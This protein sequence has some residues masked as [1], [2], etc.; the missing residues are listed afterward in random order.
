VS[1]STNSGLRWAAALALLGLACQQSV[2]PS[3]PV[4]RPDDTEDGGAPPPLG[5]RDGGADVP[6]AGPAPCVGTVFGEP[7]TKI[8]I[9][10]DEQSEQSLVVLAAD[11]DGDGKADFVTTGERNDTT[12]HLNDGQGGFQPRPLG[13]GHV[14]VGQARD[15]D[16]NGALDLVMSTSSEFTDTETIDLWLNDGRGTFTRQMLTD[17]FE[18]LTGAAIITDFDGDGALDVVVTGRIG[19]RGEAQSV[20]AFLNRGATFEELPIDAGEDGDPGLA[21]GDLDGDGRMDI[22]FRNQPAQYRYETNIIWNQPRA[23]G[24]VPDLG[25]FPVVADVDGDGRLDLVGG[26]LLMHNEGGRRFAPVKLGSRPMNGDS[27]VLAVDL[28]GDGDLDLLQRD[29]SDLVIFRQDAPMRFS[30]ARS[31]IPGKPWIIFRNEQFLRLSAADLTGDGRPDAVLSDHGGR[32]HLVSNEILLGAFSRR[33]NVGKLP[34]GFFPNQA[35][36]ADLDGDRDQDLITMNGGVSILA[37]DGRG[38]FAAVKKIEK[39]KEALGSDQGLLGDFDGDGKLDVADASYEGWVTF[40][41]NRGG[42]NLEVGPTYHLHDEMTAQVQHTAAGDLDGD[43]DLDLVTLMSSAIAVLWN[44]GNRTFTRTYERPGFNTQ[45]VA[46]GDLD[47]DGR[48]ELAIVGFTNMHHVV[49]ILKPGTDRKL[50]VGP[51]LPL[52]WPPFSV[53]IA[54]LDGDQSPEVIAGEYFG[55]RQPIAVLWNDGHGAFPRTSQHPGGAWVDVIRVAD[56]DGDGDPDILAS[57]NDTSDITVLANDGRGG[58]T[59]AGR[60][61][62]EMASGLDVADLDGRCGPDVVA[63]STTGF[64][65]WAYFAGG[66]P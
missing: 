12:L 53:A 43:G 56:F 3:R 63:N 22:V 61:F 15:V 29:T 30:E 31:S 49:R 51:E 62:A 23:I 28:D 2:P 17:R 7:T 25:S 9:D 35:F 64:A 1:A 48:P 8:L 16:K 52:P 59:L 39:P 65:L 18:G 6:P 47:R 42:L 57:A 21:A 54:D 44:E 19:P 36:A 27:P 34:A 20:R 10:I 46:I 50:V 32:A 45:Q 26:N 37:G 11:F 55:T 41:W 40:F 33:S 24:V 4:P 58:L 60:L 5:P 38:G 13:R 14:I 66:A